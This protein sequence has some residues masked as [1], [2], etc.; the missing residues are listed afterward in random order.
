M[1]IL[2]LVDKELVFD[3]L[4]N[5]LEELWRFLNHRFIVIEDNKLHQGISYTDRGD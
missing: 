3:L 1:F 4:Q 2:V 5:L